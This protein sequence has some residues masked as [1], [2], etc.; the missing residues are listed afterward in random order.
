[1]DCTQSC[2]RRHPSPSYTRGR[3]A[4][5]PS[6]WEPLR[7]SSGGYVWEGEDIG[8]HESQDP[9]HPFRL[10][11]IPVT[12]NYLR[13]RTPDERRSLYLAAILLPYTDMTILQKGKTQPAVQH[14]LKESIKSNNSDIE[15]I[16]KLHQSL[17]LVNDAVAKHA[18]SPLDR[19]ELGDSIHSLPKTLPHVYLTSFHPHNRP[20]G[21]LIRD[22]NTRWPMAVQLALAVRLFDHQDA[23]AAGGTSDE[24]QREVAAYEAVMAQAVTYGI[25]ECYTWKHIIDGKGVCTLLG[26]KPGRVISDILSDVMRWQ[27]AHPEGTVE[28]CAEFVKKEWSERVSGS[29]AKGKVG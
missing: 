15:T 25:S 18:Q 14:V 13:I 21:M 27:L 28:E 19:E 10:E 24:V 17:P 2:L 6:G 7:L 8:Y 29:A 5:Q 22:A 23:I 4:T 3:C 1:M 26:I 9:H 11:T 16:T 12:S 20:A